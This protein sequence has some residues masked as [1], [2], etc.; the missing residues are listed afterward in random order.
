MYI[1]MI[2]IIVLIL[3]IFILTN[4]YVKEGFST[5]EAIQNIAS[6]YNKDK[7]TVTNL[8]ATNNI[9]SETGNFTKGTQAIVLD[10]PV[11]DVP[12]FVKQIKDGKYFNKDTP[13]GT[14]LTIIFVHPKVNPDGNL[15]NIW[16]ASVVKLGKQFLIY[17]ILTDPGAP[18]IHHTANNL[19]TSQS[20]NATWRGNIK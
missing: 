3:F 11:W 9:T 12:A 4:E 18:Y 10:A 19:W 13:D 2:I 20:D 16:Y 6:L 14:I 1:A 7:L 8:V 15:T 5:D 17:E